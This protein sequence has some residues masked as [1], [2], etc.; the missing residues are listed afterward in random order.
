MEQIDY[1]E[2]HGI[3]GQR[4]GIRRTP[5]QL[6]HRSGKPADVSTLGRKNLKKAR[7]SNLNKWGKDA[8]HNILYIAGYSGSG[9]STTALSMAKPGDKV[10]H[11]DAYSEP[12]S[13]GAATIRN[14]D[15]DRYL[16]KA[17]PQWHDMANAQRTDTKMVRYSKEYWDTVDQFRDALDTYSRQ[18]FKQGHKVIAEGVQIADDWLTGDKTYYSDKPLVILGTNPVMSMQRAFERDDRGNLLKGLKNLDSAKE[19]IQWYS[20]TNKKLNELANTS[21]AKKGEAWVKE[22]LKQFK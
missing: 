14:K 1:L 18:Q 7:T 5:E 12:D 17:V 13:G 16:N 6:G 8:D 9:K 15:F 10:I 4:W 19:Y 22:Y 2:H 11:L 21:S 20:S 3:K